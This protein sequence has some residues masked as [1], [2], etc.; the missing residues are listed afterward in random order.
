MLPNAGVLNILTWK[1]A[2]RHSDVQFFH[3]KPPKSGPYPSSV[4]SHVPLANVLRATAAC[5]FWTSE[6]PKSVPQWGFLRILTYK[7]ASRH[8]GVPFL[9]IGTSKMAPTMRYYVHFDLQMCFAPQRRAIFPDR[10]FKNG[11][12]NK[13][14]R[15]FWLTNAFFATA[16]CHFFRIATSKMA[17]TLRC[18][19]HFDL[20]MRFAPQRRAIF[21]TRRFSEATFRT[22][23]TTN[24]LNFLRL[25]TFQ[26][27]FFRP[28]FLQP[29]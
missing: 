16:A 22:S 2:S 24:H 21:R 27:V 8:S 14:V 7:C 17:P 6:L 26:R 5:D 28:F 4:F 25:L 15:A 18:F 23:G 11:S 29:L 13:V 1:C 9:T 10:N 12:D 20:Q 3:I 19:E